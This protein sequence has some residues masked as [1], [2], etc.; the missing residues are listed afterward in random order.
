[1]SRLGV[2]KGS[3]KKT[4]YGFQTIFGFK[5]GEAGKKEVGKLRRWGKEAGKLGSYEA[6]RAE[7]KK[8]SA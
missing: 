8:R 2:R 1:M 3:V 4:K 6:W 5:L 7:G